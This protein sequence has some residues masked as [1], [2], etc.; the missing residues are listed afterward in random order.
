[1]SQFHKLVRDKIPE[2][3]RLRGATP[4]VRFL[5][6]KDFY[7][8]LLEKLHEEITEFEVNPSVEELADVC[9]VLHGLALSLGIPFGGIEQARLRK[10]EERGGFE[11]RILLEGIDEPP[12]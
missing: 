8:S 10:Y 1:M 2:I 3:I 12:L 9:E 11:Q 5:N 6:E 7:A 4:H